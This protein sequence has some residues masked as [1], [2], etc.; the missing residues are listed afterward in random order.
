MSGI[1]FF[2]KSKIDLSLGDLV[3]ITIED[4]IADNTGEDIADYIRDRGNDSGWATTGSSDAANTRMTIIFGDSERISEILMIQNNFKSYLIEY[5]DGL[6][7]Q[8]LD[9]ET[10][11]SEADVRITFAPL[12]TDRLRLTVYGTMVADDDKFL[13]QLIVTDL[14]GQLETMVSIDEVRIGR[15]RKALEV[16]SGKM[17]LQRSV[18]AVSMRI[19]HNNVVNNSDLAL[20]ERLYESIDGFLV[21]LC[22]DDTSQFRNQ[23]TGY[24]RKDIYLMNIPTEY[25]PS[26]EGGFYKNGIPID[27]RLVEVV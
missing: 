23:V 7:W 25:G 12:E 19:R 26:W 15:K 4:A 3:S 24:R 17:K 2:E 13:S 8:S 11:N 20:V 6:A 14:I 1:L 27:F 18:G 16:L 10:N 22:G 9:S 5:W 21:W